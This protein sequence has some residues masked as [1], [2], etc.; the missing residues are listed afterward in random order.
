MIFVGRIPRRLIYK[1]FESLDEIPLPEIIRIDLYEKL[2]EKTMKLVNEAYYQC[3]LI[4][5]DD[6]PKNHLHDFISIA[7]HNTGNLFDAH[8][9][10][11]ITYFLLRSNKDIPSGVEEILP[12]IKKYVPIE[13]ALGN[14]LFNSLSCLIPNISEMNFSPQVVAPNNIGY[15]DWTYITRGYMS[16]WIMKFIKLWQNKD[17]QLMVYK[18]IYS[19][20][21]NE[22]KLLLADK[23]IDTIIKLEKKN[24]EIEDTID[25][26]QSL[27]FELKAEVNVKNNLLDGF[28]KDL[29][30]LSEK[31]NKSS[32][33]FSLE[34][35]IDYIL[36]HEKTESISLMLYNLEHSG[37][38]ITES[39][40]KQIHRLKGVNE[41]E[42][43]NVTNISTNGGPV[44]LGGKF[45]K[46]EFVAQKKI[47][48]K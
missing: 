42:K 44:I 4:S 7:E 9:V 19:N 33:C 5:L 34:K 45:D 15:V 31:N 47:E 46:T 36:N 2:G 41:K 30:V 11:S 22:N 18:Q 1:E 38:D 17:D 24:K 27:V 13:W 3:I 14:D 12:D 6:N 8:I 39:E 26:L 10:L 35:I 28:S 29:K 25:K 43:H 23:N 20:A 32:G 16:D 48:S 40:K 21:S 37:D